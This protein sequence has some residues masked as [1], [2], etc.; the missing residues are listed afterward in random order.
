VDAREHVAIG[1]STGV[2]FIVALR[3]LEREEQFL[4]AGGIA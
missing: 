3:T 1:D 2:T 4:V